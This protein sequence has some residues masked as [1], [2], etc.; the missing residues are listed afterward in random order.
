MQNHQNLQNAIFNFLLPFLLLFSCYLL[1]F[2]FWQKNFFLGVLAICLLICF[3]FFFNI[4]HKNSF[5][6]LLEIVLFSAILSSLIY[7]CCFCFII[8]NHI[9]TL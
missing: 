2:A 3:L 6:P 5:L 7:I 4:H 9:S 8:F 1:L